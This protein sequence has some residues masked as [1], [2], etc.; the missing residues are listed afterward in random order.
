MEETI[1]SDSSVAIAAMPPLPT[2]KRLLGNRYRLSGL[3]RGDD[4][5]DQ[6]LATDMVTGGKVLVR[7]WALPTV[8]SS[9]RLRM[10]HEARLLSKLQEPCLNRILETGEDGDRF[11]AVQPWVRGIALRQR[12]SRA[13]LDLQEVFTLGRCLFSALKAVH[14]VGILHHEIHPANVIVNDSSPLVE[15]VLTGF[16]LG[17]RANPAKWNVHD[18]MEAARYRSPEQAG[19]VDYDIGP[20]S[21]LYSAGIVLFECLAG[22][23]PFG[24][25]TVGT[26]LLEHMTCRIPELRSL[27]LNI[28]R[29]LDELI[30]RLL[31]KDPRDRYQTA[32]AVLLDL[33]EIAASLQSDA[34]DPAFVVGSHDRR[35]TLTEPAFVGRQDELRQLEEQIEQVIAGG[36]RLVFVEAESGGGKTR[37]LAEAALRGMQAGMWALR[38]RGSEIVGQLPFQVLSGIVE[39]VVAAARSNPDLA[40]TL[41]ERLGDHVN[42]VATMLPEL[43]RSLGWETPPAAGPEQF[44]ETRSVQAL[45][46]FLGGLGAETRPALIILDDCQWAA[47][48]TF[49][50]IAQWQRELASP[51]GNGRPTLLV[52]AFRSEE[53]AAEHP[54]RKLRPSLHL[55]LGRFETEDVQH[56]LESMAGPL[57]AGAI[58]VVCKLSEGSPFMAS[59]V[60]R[61]MAES[62]ALLAE[63]TGWR[64]EPLALA[65]LQSSGRAAG[66]LARR[67]ELLPRDALDLLTIGAVLGKEF[68]L[69]LAAKLLVFS[70][71]QVAA[72]LELI[73]ARHFV[74]TRPDGTECTFVHDKIRAALL[75]RLLPENL[76]ELHH[77]CAH[78]LQREKAGRIFDLAYHFDAAG[79]HEAALPYALQAAEQAR[80]RHALEMAEGQ[81]RI[82][83]RGAQSAENTAHYAIAKGLGDVLMLRGRYSE[84]EELFQAALGLADGTLA[85]VE[86][87][88]RLGETRFQARRHGQS[89][90]GRRRGAAAARRNRPPKTSLSVYSCCCG[91]PLFRP[92]IPCCRASS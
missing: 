38:G 51:A 23:V 69:D 11:Y 66:F 83:Q 47:E 10:E 58:E 54:L 64:I 15:A 14:E 29:S 24:G 50:V 63:P 27:G 84:A 40:S 31:R 18:S 6:M 52:V 56:L 12:L 1:H 13:A 26:V 34:A 39:D 71:S 87:R 74:W 45:A 7:W 32:E 25:D 17:C 4:L 65:D 79:D 78:H 81:Y 60:L 36:S 5:P 57:P 72:A 20:T 92:L 59:A 62:G 86:M 2:E 55:Q 16:S 89:G 41:R 61:G 22:R 43:G 75:A 42:A 76:R 73:R 53:V 49:K 8:S 67:I 77:L 21:D 68:D 48:M 28:P 37:L 88:G 33:E 9:A 3:V 35:P 85:E 44:V 80:A 30:Q 91:R 19:S 82:A 90:A 46:A 70:P